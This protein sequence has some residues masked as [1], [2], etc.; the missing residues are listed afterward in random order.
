M[1][2]G[3][4]R[5]YGRHINEWFDDFGKL[6]QVEVE[7]NEYSLE[8]ASL[9]GTGSEDF[10]GYRYDQEIISRFYKAT[11]GEASICGSINFCRS[12]EKLVKKYLEIRYKGYDVE[13]K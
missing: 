5:I 9:V 3:K 4:V 8:N 10:S 6:K 11:H 12:D 7:Y 1:K 2:F 13:I